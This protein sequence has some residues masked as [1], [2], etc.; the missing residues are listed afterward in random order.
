M[1][2]ESIEFLKLL[3]IIVCNL[4]VLAWITV[5]AFLKFVW[6]RWRMRRSGRFA[7][8]WSGTKIRRFGWLLG[9]VQDD[10]G[11]A[12]DA[13]ATKIRRE[14]TKVEWG[15]WTEALPYAEIYSNKDDER[16][17]AI[18]NLSQVESIESIEHAKRIIQ[19][20][21][22]NPST[23]NNVRRVAKAALEEL[24]NRQVK[25]IDDIEKSLESTINV[26]ENYGD[27]DGLSSAWH[28]LAWTMV[29]SGKLAEAENCILRSIEVRGQAGPT[30]ELADSLIKLAEIRWS[31]GEYIRAMELLEQA[32]AFLKKVG[33]SLNLVN[34]FVRIGSWLGSVK[35]TDEAKKFFQRAL[36]IARE[37]ESYQEAEIRKRM[38]T[39]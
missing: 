33:D 32:V 3:W 23:S 8:K 17:L 10:L 24:K 38:N 7:P 11:S 19:G 22:T 27:L 20:I 16:C 30:T 4:A 1:A 34:I 28:N 35:E 39:L 31:Q 14:L 13:M 21:V 15:I 18:R 5:P 12:R 6:P 36:R 2:R 29:R 9:K 26:F 25:S 37:A